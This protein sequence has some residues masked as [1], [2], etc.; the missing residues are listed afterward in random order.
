MVK[1]HLNKATKANKFYS[2]NILTFDYPIFVF[3]LVF[4][5]SFIKK[6]VNVKHVYQT[7]SSL[8]IQ[9][10][11]IKLFLEVVLEVLHLHHYKY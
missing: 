11:P 10:F 2:K 3:H 5:N 9:Y 8:L 6:K 1:S 4:N 7:N